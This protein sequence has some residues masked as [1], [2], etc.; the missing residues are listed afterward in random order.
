MLVGLRDGVSS[1]NP[2]EIVDRSLKI[3][4]S[5]DSLGTFST[6]HY[7][8]EQHIVPAQ[9]IITHTYPLDQYI[10]AFSAL[11]CDLNER[12]LNPSSHAIKVILQSS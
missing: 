9:K 11:G 7:M 10:E 5:I 8:I 1:F 6:A 12:T 3:I 4:G 2:K